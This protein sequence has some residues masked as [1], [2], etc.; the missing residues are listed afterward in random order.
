MA[1]DIGVL[2][3]FRGVSSGSLSGSQNAWFAKMGGMG[4]LVTSAVLF[5]VLIAVII[6]VMRKLMMYNVDVYVFKKYTTGMKL[7]KL[8]GRVFQDKSSKYWFE[9][10]PASFFKLKAKKINMVDQ[11]YFISKEK[12]DAVFLFQIGREDYK[13]ML[14]QEC[15][16]QL[17]Q[18]RMMGFDVVDIS[19]HNHSIQLQ[20][21]VIDRRRNSNKLLIYLPTLM[22]VAGMIFVV[23]LL[24]MTLGRIETMNGA[25]TVGY[26]K[27]AAA[28]ADFGKQ[29][30]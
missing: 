13:P 7:V 15:L 18:E 4:T 12:G 8:K 16:D 11:E 9:V 17:T 24:W 3:W 19:A 6:I 27:M 23:V 25:M 1:A 29:I 30:I 26:E 14:F 10:T 28:I 20:Q 2:S 22:M 21:E 5:F